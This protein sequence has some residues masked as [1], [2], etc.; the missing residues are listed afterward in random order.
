MGQKVNPISF[1]ISLTKDWRSRWFAT[2]QQFGDNL[3]EDLAIRKHV[4][5]QLLQA[6]IS[7]IQI[8][9]SGN[10]VR[11]TVHTSRPGLVFG[12]KRAEL[13]ALKDA[14]HALTGGKDVYIDVVEVKRPEMD[15]QLV[16]E[17]IAMQIER[18]I[19]FRRAMKKSI[20]TVMDMGADGVRIRCAG[21]LN[22]AELA[23]EEQYK[24]GK[25]PLHTL[26]ANVQYGFAEAR[27]PA[28]LIGIKTWICVPDNMEEQYDANDAKAGKT[29]K[30]AERKPR[31]KRKQGQ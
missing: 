2:K 25:V 26:R 31:R 7:R 9:R 10:R 19:G 21:R 27:T 11:V 30:G 6:G 12:R 8:E 22:G 4:K 5:A 20:Q 23:R 29:P 1:R 24:Q 16:A 13:D 14:L 3:H 28:G 15:A 18:R 17:N